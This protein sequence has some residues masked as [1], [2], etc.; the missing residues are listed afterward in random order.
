MPARSGCTIRLKKPI[1]DLGDG[2]DT[3]LLSRFFLGDTSEAGHHPI[4]RVFA[5]NSTVP[6]ALEKVVLSDDGAISAVQCDEQLHNARLDDGC[7]AIEGDF[8]RCRANLCR[9]NA[10]R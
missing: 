1:P 9:A 2:L 7:A 3:E 4:D 10:E 6:T 8:A 5:D